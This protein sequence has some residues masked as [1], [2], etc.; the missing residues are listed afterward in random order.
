MSLR[1]NAAKGIGLRFL[2]LEKLAQQSVV[3]VLPQF[4]AKAAQNQPPRSASIFVRS[5]TK[6]RSMRLQRS[7]TPTKST[8]S[9][10]PS[11]PST[12]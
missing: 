8:I 1:E 5:F 2:D 9:L 11:C 10:R 3:E 12:S 4:R 7:S 6:L